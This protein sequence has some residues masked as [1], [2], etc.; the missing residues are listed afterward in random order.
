MREGKSCSLPATP[1]HP[2]SLRHTTA[3]KRSLLSA[4]EARVVSDRITGRPLC[5]PAACDALDLTAR[6]CAADSSRVRSFYT[7]L[8][9]LASYLLLAET[10][11]TMSD[12]ATRALRQ[13]KTWGVRE[14]AALLD[15]DVSAG[16]EQARVCVCVLDCQPAHTAHGRP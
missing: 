8:T 2:H 16:R 3:V 15:E 12:V 5:A 4:A 11:P 1:T 13:M 14:T 6:V 10:D 9:E 7:V